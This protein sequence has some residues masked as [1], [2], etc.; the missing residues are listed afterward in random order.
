VKPRVSGSKRNN[1]PLP[2]LV[3]TP[4]TSRSE[5]RRVDGAAFFGLSPS[6]VMPNTIATVA[7]AATTTLIGL[8]MRTGSDESRRATSTVNAPEMGTTST[9]LAS[10]G[11]RTTTPI[12]VSAT[13]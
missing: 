6:R 11:R 1:A 8:E 7:T 4:A 2:V 5:P 3:S 9:W 13:R 12:K 10:P